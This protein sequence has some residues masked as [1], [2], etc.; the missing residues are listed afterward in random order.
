MKVAAVEKGGFYWQNLGGSV[1]EESTVAT[2]NIT[3]TTA[4]LVRASGSKA[5]GDKEMYITFASSNR[6][7][8]LLPIEL[9]SFTAT[10]K[11][12]SSLVEWTTATENNND[13]FELERSYDAINFE[14]IARVAGAGNSLEPINYAYNDYGVSNGNIYYRLVQ[15]DYDGTRTAS[16]IIAVAC[17]DKA[18]GNPDVMAYPNPFSGELTL[19]LDNF[20]NRPANIE[21][22]DMLGRLVMQ[23]KADAPQNSYEVTL[24]LDNLPSATYTIRIST[25][26]FVINRNVV[27]N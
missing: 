7:E 3:A 23:D 16:E 17:N 24:H 5:A 18:D 14:K 9:T 20:E 25:N 10:C 1:S 15:V 19:V 11:G 21:I 4:L 13:H 26:D 6:G 2:G 22:Y 27:K 8:L 12:H